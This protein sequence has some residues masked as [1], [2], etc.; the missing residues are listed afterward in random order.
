MGAIILIILLVVAGLIIKYK[1]NSWMAQGNAQNQ[2]IVGQINAAKNGDVEAMFWLGMYYLEERSQLKNLSSRRAEDL[3]N[4]SVHWFM[5]AVECG[6]TRSM[7]TLARQYCSVFNTDQ[8]GET[9]ITNNSG[10]GY[11]P[12][13]ELA[14]TRM[15]AE[16]GDASGQYRLA[17]LINDDRNKLYWLEQS[18]NQGYFRAYQALGDYYR[19]QF[20]SN[21][22]KETLAKAEYYYYLAMRSNDD[23]I[24]SQ[25]AY[26]LG[27]IFGKKYYFGKDPER[28]AYW[29][30]QSYLWGN[31]YAKKH[32]DEIIENAKITISENKYQQW[33]SDFENHHYLTDELI[34]TQSTK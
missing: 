5:Q 13:E 20:S 3:K 17:T 28:S 15:A 19:Q 30:F 12:E 2:A 27:E 33:R 31:E 34:I 10:F 4:R 24:C 8:S 22:K 21:N 23:F 1:F 7:L 25:A 11:D 16:A 32:L 14:L 29:F 6:D 18:A 26:Q 9:L